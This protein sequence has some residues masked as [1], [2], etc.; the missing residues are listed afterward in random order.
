MLV[1]KKLR[2]LLI[3]LACASLLLLT[4]CSSQFNEIKNLNN[5]TGKQI[6]VLGDSITAGYGL[7]PQQAYPNL[8]AQQLDLDLPILNRGVSGDT[9]AN[10]LARLRKDVI[11]EQPWLVIIGLGGN[12]FLRKIPKSATETNLNVMITQVQAEGAITVL[13]GMNL[14]LFK[15][16]YQEIYARLAQDTGSYLIPQVLKGIIDNPKH[17][18]QDIIHP[19][20]KGQ[21]I[22]ANRIAKALNSD[23]SM[24]HKII[25]HQPKRFK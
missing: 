6:I 23:N 13:L 5:G 24:V 16:E 17:R 14:G 2:I 4:N 11:D 15:D 1:P 9:T 19:N 10:G 3:S 12:D 8:L 20:Q 18:Q 22:L 25:D 7:T 21:E